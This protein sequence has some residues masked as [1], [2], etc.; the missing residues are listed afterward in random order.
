[1]GSPNI[2]RQQW[3]EDLLNTLNIPPTSGALSDLVAWS[4]AEGGWWDNPDNFNPLNTTENAP[5]AVAT[6]SVGVKSYPDLQTGLTATADSL[7]KTNFGKGDPYS[8]ILNDLNAGAPVAQFAADVGASPWGTSQAGILAAAGQSTPRG[9]EMSISLNPVND[10]IA[11]WKA[12]GGAVGSGASAL[13]PVNDINSITGAVANIPK[14]LAKGL[15]TV[16]FIVASF[17]LAIGG[18]FMMFKKP[19]GSGSMPMPVPV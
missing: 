11:G 6:N 14:D 7:T 3:A 8:Q 1:M 4:V 13:N 5:G 17:V 12:V 10:V 9:G 2:T 19:G 16:V 18:L 15:I